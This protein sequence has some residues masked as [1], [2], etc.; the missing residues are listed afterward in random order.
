VL[1]VKSAHAERA[2]VKKPE[3]V[4]TAKAAEYKGRIEEAIFEHGLGSR[5]KVQ[6]VGNTLTLSGKLH[7]AEHGALLKFLRD[8]P[9]A[10]HLIDHI[11]YDDAPQPSPASANAN[12]STGGHPVPGPGFGAI[13]VVTDV[14]GANAMLY[15][16]SGRVVSQCLTPCSFNNLTPDR[17]S[18]EVKKDGYQPVQTAL[19]VKQ[20]G[21]ADQK[22]SLESLAK[23]L[24]VTSDPPGADVFINGA[25]QSGQTPVNLPL[26][27]GQYNLVLRLQGYDPYVGSVQVKDNGQAQVN[28]KL[29]ERSNNHIAWAQVKSDPGGAEIFVDGNSTGRF[30]PARV[31]IAAG[32]HTVTLKLEGFQTA[33]RTV[34]ASEGGTVLIDQSLRK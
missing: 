19:Q 13:H 20:G 12:T 14:I 11:E 5:A 6:G 3:P 31:E 9:P 27:A 29:K 17:Y 32:M 21:V 30:T 15:G 1:D 23:G 22:L 10:I 25:K 7:P 2:P 24:R 28:T 8:A 16:P 33:K 18:L 4:L 26:A 34:S